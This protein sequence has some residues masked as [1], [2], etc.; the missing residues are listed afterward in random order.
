MNKR[1]GL[2]FLLNTAIAGSL[3]LAIHHCYVKPNPDSSS[4]LNK[5]A[6]LLAPDTTNNLRFGRSTNSKKP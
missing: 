2:V 4:V 6:R 3:S 1:S 5:T